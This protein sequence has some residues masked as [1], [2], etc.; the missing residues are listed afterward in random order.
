M[1]QRIGAWNRELDVGVLVSPVERGL[2]LRKG[3]VAAVPQVARGRQGEHANPFGTV[4]IGGKVQRGTIASGDRGER[5]NAVGQTDGR[6]IDERHA[7]E[8]ILAQVGIGPTHEVNHARVRGQGI[9]DQIGTE[10]GRR[11]TAVDLDRMRQV[12]VEN[13]R[14][15]RLDGVGGRVPHQ[16]NIGAETGHNRGVINTS[17]VVDVAIVDFQGA[18]LVER[19]HGDVGERA[20]V[21]EQDRPAVLNNGHTSGKGRRTGDGQRPAT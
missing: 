20:I 14:A 19:N 2:L 9:E 12:V 6:R 1:V 17:G 18:V 10:R 11:R 16:L 15:E 8:A 21:L 13:Q 4:G 3:R 7:I 5:P